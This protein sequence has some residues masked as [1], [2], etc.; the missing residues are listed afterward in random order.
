MKKI[1]FLSILIL[2][3]SPIITAGFASAEESITL[4]KGQTLYVPAYS[5]IYAGD[6]ELPMLLTVTLSIRNIDVNHPITLIYADYHGTKGELIKK[7]VEKSILIK[8]LESIRYVIPQKDKSG[9]SGANFMVQWESD[10]AVNPPIIESVM[11]G[12]EGQ[13]GISFTSRGEVITTSN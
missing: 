9:G 8:P 10:K 7:Y 3:W 13:Q 6:R 1:F 5:H 12:T 11:I 2:L 4:S